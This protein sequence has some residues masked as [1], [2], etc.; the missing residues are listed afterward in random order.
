[1]HL[2]L[3]NKT[4]L[5]TGSSKGIGRKIA[6]ALFQEGC[7][8]ALNSRNKKDLKELEKKLKSSI[9]IEGDVTVPSEAKRIVKEAVSKLGSLDILI[10]NVG[11]GKSV[12]P[13]FENHNEWEKILNQN[14]KSTTNMVEESK[15]YLSDSKGV[16]VCISSICGLETVLDAPITYSVAKSALNSYVKSVARPLGQIGVRINAIT[17]GNIIFEGSVWENKLKEDPLKVN[18]M[19]HKEVALKKLGKPEDISALACFLVSPVANFIT[20]SVFKVDGGQTRS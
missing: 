20:G 13:G 10:C 7:I 4:A 3:K 8:V 11:S 12:K 6:E 9:C 18:E 17:P 16:I 14:L 15:C 19:L 1:M 5:V 2:N